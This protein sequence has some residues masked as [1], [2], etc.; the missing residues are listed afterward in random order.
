[1]SEECLL[2]CIALALV[3]LLMFPQTLHVHW[4][5]VE[6]VITLVVKHMVLI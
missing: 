2:V 3:E 6:V 1:M 5:A 4:L